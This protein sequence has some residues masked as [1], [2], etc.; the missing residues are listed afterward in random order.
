MGVAA[1]LLAPGR[2][3]G[4]LAL[5]WLLLCVGVAFKVAIQRWTSGLRTHVDLAT[6]FSALYLVVGGRWFV[7][8]RFGWRPLGFATVIV[9]LTAVHAREVGMASSLLGAQTL[10]QVARDGRRVLVARVAVVAIVASPPL[11]AAGFTFSPWL[12]VAGGSV[13]ATGLIR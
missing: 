10:G 4:I 6:L 1:L 9:E 11:V 8:A 12:Q 7:V 5:P 2:L 13:L 3:A